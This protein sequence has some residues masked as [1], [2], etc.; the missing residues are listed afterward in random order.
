MVVQRTLKK[1]KFLLIVAQNKFLT[2]NSLT[3]KID[4]TQQN[5][6]ENL[7]Y[8]NSILKTLVSKIY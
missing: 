6:I 8:I 7:R 4:R 2:T 1:N 5:N 3:A